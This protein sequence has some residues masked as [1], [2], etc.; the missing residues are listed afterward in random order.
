[1]RK[2]R[3]NHAIFAVGPKTASDSDSSQQAQ[4]LRAF[5][6]DY[7]NVTSL[8]G[9]Q[10]FSSSIVFFNSQSDLDNYMTDVNYDKSGYG[11]G[12]VA[13]AV[14]FYSVDLLS[15]N[16]DYAIRVNY[17]SLFDQNDPTVACLYGSSSC[18]FTYT[19]PSTL[20]NSQ[21]LLKPQ[22]SEYLYGYTYSAFS[23]I[24]QIVDQYIFTIT[25]NKST[26]INGVPA[27]NVM[28]S[29][30][31]MPTTAYKTDNFQYIISSTLGI[32]Y[33]LSF[34]YPVSRIIRSLVLDKE[35]RVR[36]G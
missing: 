23:S 4:S 30:S 20:Y 14:V 1:M 26:V 28:A 33:M 13:F 17:T 2:I 8:N 19:I 24:Q 15:H 34:L 32:F 6:I 21:N 16:W 5:L 12:K 11:Y 22:S 7:C 9:T 36:E 10:D 18:S 25:S 27:V 31:L 3:S 29:V 35:T